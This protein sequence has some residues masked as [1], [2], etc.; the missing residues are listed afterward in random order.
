MPPPLI[1]QNHA[2]LNCRPSWAALGRASSAASPMAA[3]K[4]RRSRI[5]ENLEEREP[6]P[7]SPAIAG[8]CLG[9]GGAVRGHGRTRLGHAGTPSARAGTE[10]DPLHTIDETIAPPMPPE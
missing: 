5:V 9:R 4:T 10:V 2:S 7:Q 8:S 6:R 1:P 3:V